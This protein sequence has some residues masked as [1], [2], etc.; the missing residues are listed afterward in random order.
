MQVF[1]IIIMLIEILITAMVSSH[2]LAKA[3]GGSLMSPMRQIKY[4]VDGM[5]SNKNLFGFI[6][7]TLILVLLIPAFVIIIVVQIIAC[8][9]VACII[10]WQLGDKS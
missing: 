10:I 3:I 7:S 2:I 8:I 6:L 1:L 9:N 4:F 5:F